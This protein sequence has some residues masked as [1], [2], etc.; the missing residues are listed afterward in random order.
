MLPAAAARLYR[1][2]EKNPRGVW[3]FFI[4]MKIFHLCVVLISVGGNSLIKEQ[5]MIYK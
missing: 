3:G 1:K 5:K 2:K 4:F